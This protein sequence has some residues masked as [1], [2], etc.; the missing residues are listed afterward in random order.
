MVALLFVGGKCVGMCVCVCMCHILASLSSLWAAIM[1]C[2]ET[3]CQ[4]NESVHRNEQ[5]TNSD[6]IDIGNFEVGIYFRH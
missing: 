2:T 4:Y 6:F 5:H 3:H 1:M